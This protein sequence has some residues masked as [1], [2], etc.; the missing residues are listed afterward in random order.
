MLNSSNKGGMVFSRMSFAMILIYS[1][2]LIPPPSPPSEVCIE[3]MF[4][5]RLLAELLKYVI[6]ALECSPKT[7]GAVN[8]GIWSMNVR[9]CSYVSS[10]GIM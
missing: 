3:M 2:L 9:F 5:H 7:P 1:S 10:D 4:S 8:S 6:S